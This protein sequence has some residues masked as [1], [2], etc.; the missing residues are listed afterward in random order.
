M[1]K[2]LKSLTKHLIVL[3]TVIA[4][5]MSAALLTPQADFRFTGDDLA[6]Q[7][8]ATVMIEDEEGLGSG[9]VIGPRTVLTAAHVAGEPGTEL[10]VTT[11]DGREIDAFTLWATE[12]NL[13]GTDLAMVR[14]AEP[15]QVGARINCEARPAVGS[16]V[17]VIGHALGVPFSVSSGEVATYR[18]P[19]IFDGTQVG[20]GYFLNANVL[21]GNSGGPIFQ[22]GKLVGLA[23]GVITFG[24]GFG[25][26][27]TG[28]GIAMS[29]KPICEALAIQ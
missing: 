28:L 21:P 3:F 2:I 5:T 26:S 14:L 10:T 29:T 6:M 22:G 9:V 4:V 11:F 16:T 7:R 17:K 20:N 19:G 15:V 27:P 8:A 12:I 13:P 18:Y 25:A 24:F 23:N 1:N